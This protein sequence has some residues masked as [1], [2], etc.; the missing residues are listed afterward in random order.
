MKKIILSTIGASL[1]LNG[2][3][4]AKAINPT[5]QE[6]SAKAVQK[7]TQKVDDKRLKL[8]KEA[9]SSL[10]LSASALK[11][12]N[13]NKSDKAKKDIELALGKLESILASKH[14]PELLPI[15]QKVIVKNFI[16][17]AKDVKASVEKVKELLDDG[18]IQEAGDLLISLQSEIDITTVSLPLKTY[19]DALK[20]VSKY[21][22]EEQP[23]KAKEILKV[24]LSTFSETKEIIPIPLVNTLRLVEVAS[25]VAK[26][27]K[28]QAL[29]YLKSAN[30]ELNKAQ[31]LG[32]ISES[33]T[34][35]KELHKLI[36]GVE[37]EVEGPN[38]AEKLFKELG[39]KI[40][41]FKEKIFSKN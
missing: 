38:K 27:D 29:K 20:L 34:T 6:V 21:I 10:E 37:K 24:A 39:N 32:Y 14:A 17:S 1:L 23:K 8:V 31:E 33:T 19:P 13:E 36:K 26:K 28:E 25:D 15:D 2:V 30:E 40:K 22:I 9:L 3:L 18:K 11:E 7:E 41:E 5:S 35:Y 16:G 12:L 4:F